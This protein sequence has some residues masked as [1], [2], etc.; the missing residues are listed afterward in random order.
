MSVGADRYY[1]PPDTDGR[2]AEVLARKIASET[3]RYLG[4][5]EELATDYPSDQSLLLQQVFE[6]MQANRTANLGEMDQIQRRFNNQQTMNDL[7]V[8]WTGAAKW[9]AEFHN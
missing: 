8:W 9:T 7:I 5:P 6:I 4:A 3:A 1:E 2:E